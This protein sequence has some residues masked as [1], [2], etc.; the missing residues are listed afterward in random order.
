M[1]EVGGRLGKAILIH[2]LQAILTPSEQNGCE[3]GSH[4]YVTGLTC[5]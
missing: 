3:M 2:R 5:L 4:C 1:C